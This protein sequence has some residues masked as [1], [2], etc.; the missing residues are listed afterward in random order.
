MVH[1]HLANAVNIY[2]C[3]SKTNLEKLLIKQKQA[4]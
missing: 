4:I 3:A 1:S 2:G